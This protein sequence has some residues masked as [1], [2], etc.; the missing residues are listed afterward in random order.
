MNNKNVTPSSLRSASEK[1]TQQLYDDLSLKLLL[2]I[3][4]SNGYDTSRTISIS[5]LK[6]EMQITYSALAKLISRLKQDLFIIIEIDENDELYIKI[7][8][9]GLNNLA[10]SQVK[11]NW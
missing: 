10:N 7:T 9:S 6:D 8:T 4:K 11:N 3:A 1:S 5:K 2:L